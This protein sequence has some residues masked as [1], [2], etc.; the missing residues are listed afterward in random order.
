MSLS[1]AINTAQTIFNNT[2]AQTALVSKN[3]QNVSNADYSRRMAM[4]GTSGNGAQIVLPFSA[5]RTTR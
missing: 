5:P 3:I 1:S 4:L 2:A